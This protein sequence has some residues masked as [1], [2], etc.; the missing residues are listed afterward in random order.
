MIV[1]TISFV[2]SFLF[3]WSSLFPQNIFIRNI[4]R[5]DFNELKSPVGPQNWDVAQDTLG[6]IWVANTSTVL[7]FDG[8]NWSAV[9]STENKGIR[10]FI[11]NDDQILFAGGDE[12]IG[13]FTQD[14][15]GLPI[16]ASL[17]HLLKE[18]DRDIGTVRSVA[19]HNNAVFFKT[20][21]FLIMYQ[22]DSVKIW[23]A[24]SRQNSLS[25]LDDGILFQNDQYDLL[26]LKDEKIDTLYKFE[27]H[28]S[29]RIIKGFN[30]EPNGYILFS[31]KSGIYILSGNQLRKYPTQIDDLLQN[32][33]IEEVKQFGD[34][35][36]VLATKGAGIIFLDRS[37]SLIKQINT[38]KG[39][40]SN[41]CYNMYRDKQ[42]GW[43]LCLDNGISRMEYP[44]A[45]T[46]FDVT[47]GLEGIVLTTLNTGDYLYVGTT[48]GLY[49]IQPDSEENF[50][51]IENVG[52][53]WDVKSMNERIWVASSDGIF[54]VNKT[55]AKKIVEV[56]ARTI[57]ASHHSDLIWAGL[58]K[59]FGWLLLS[60]GTWKWHES[61]V[62]VDHQIRTIAQENDSV[63][64][65]SD[66]KLSRLVFDTKR[67]KMIR[68]QTF[69]KRQGL[70]EDFWIIESYIINNKLLLGTPKGLYRFDEGYDLFIPDTT[71]GKLFANQGRDAYALA[72]DPKGQFWLS[73]NRASG[74]LIQQVDG[75]YQWD[76]LGLSRLIK[77]D[78]W[79]IVP[80]ANGIVWFCTT[81]GL[82]KYD[83][84]VKSSFEKNY[85]TLINQIALNGDSVIFYHWNFSGNP[86]G[87]SIHFPVLDFNYNSIRFS[88]SSTSYNVGE[89]IQY[90]YKLEGYDEHWS[91]WVNESIKEYTELSPKTYHFKIKSRNLY[92]VET[93]E[94][95]FSFSILPPW[96]R[97]WLAY[98]FYG[99]F[100]IGL[101]I[102]VD[103]IQRKR[104]YLRQQAKIR[105]QEK[106]LER[107]REIS[108]KLRKVDKLKDEFL[109][110]TSHEL[111]TP[112]NGIIGIS[113]SL[114]D[115]LDKM[116]RNLV[117]KNLSM[118]VSS[119][120]RLANMVNS[121]LDYSKLKSKELELKI[122]K[123][124]LSSL[125]EIVLTM[126]K[127]LI[128]SDKVQILNQIPID[129]PMVLA[130]ENRLQQILYNLIGNAI[131]FTEK[132]SIS[133][134]AEKNNNMALI[135]VKD[136]GM[137]IPEDKK[138][139][140]FESYEQ[141]DLDVNREFI[142]T[143]LGLT[144]S[145][146]LVEL[147]GGSIWVESSLNTGSRFYFT[148]PVSD[149]KPDPLVSD[150]AQKP[151][152]EEIGMKSKV[153]GKGEFKIL[154]VD[155][156]PVNR[157]VL[158]NHLREEHYHLTLA[159]SGREALELIEREPFDLILLDVMM[160]GT[161]GYEVCLKI[162]EVHTLNEL[163]VIFITAKD[164][165]KDLVEGLSYGGNDYIT[166]PFSKQE[167]L[168]RIRTHLKLLKIN[169]SYSRFIP[170]EFI[171][172]LGRESIM[173]VHLGD[174]I[175][176]E[177]T[178]L[179]TDIRDYT[180][181]AEKMS[182]SENF[183]FLNSFLSKI[184]PVIRKN[185][186]FIMH[187]LGDGLMALFPDDASNAVLASVEIQQALAQFNMAG[188]EKIPGTVQVGTGMHTG[189]LILGILGDD[190]RMDANV[191]SDAVNTASRM[192]GLTKYYGASS[193]ISE[194]T[195]SNIRNEKEINH[196]FLGLVRVKGKS[197]PLKIYELLDGVE[198]E[199]NRLKIELKDLF[200]KG[201]EH[202]FSQ[203]FVEAASVFK[204]V[205]LKNP[206]DLG[207]NKYL[208]ICARL[209]VDG[210]DDT[211]DGVESMVTK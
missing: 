207:A 48:N 191:V 92:K 203:E 15:R 36:Y 43:W 40:Q 145:K 53:V 123:V 85:R 178:I 162:R 135:S 118:V 23:E 24:K 131:K 109:A 173:D 205:S 136:T 63:L 21:D 196:R 20:S 9:R 84:R 55:I 122:K 150:L 28:K 52:E 180:T 116:D 144:I 11:L 164:Q 26:V 76:T 51:R 168:A 119:G 56:K 132:G 126:S 65:V 167:L 112:L 154:I 121:I 69:D 148:L 156:E 38:R 129:F 82:Y 159:S 161:S 12:D 181:L 165:I 62:Q 97:T 120:K 117:L 91:D 7:L 138:E 70:T 128:S 60:E 3:I 155:D 206:S 209:M 110:H 87:K 195:L 102:V 210:V 78:I 49:Y 83:T 183:K 158:I 13:Y 17:M 182:P 192:E 105:M 16:Y 54:I 57:A 25:Q 95:S 187:Y 208:R 73:S 2:F 72:E 80:D 35:Q 115:Q 89:N 66:D 179:F 19:V 140:I 8:I 197:N 176:K 186:G 184:G 149:I 125:V 32:I 170:Y 189:K 37:G 81:D 163:P 127:P 1:K 6:R 146:N 143:G 5:N 93:K 14:G 200:E 114:Q 137:G 188:P 202:Y 99:L 77:T 133:I 124:D 61:E 33:E 46:Y 88:F 160:P 142:G 104:L 106:E 94:T 147:H 96:Y 90:S 79:R 47:N 101:I 29:F 194:D 45:L 71:Y 98:G 130:D 30:I 174:Q 193:I 50:K 175:E 107:E 18:E 68:L 103:R 27:N 10:N 199:T 41:T 204:T 74:P 111:R 171:R 67:N 139:R 31:E 185:N 172:S 39:L 198:S 211:W 64:W 100:G 201:L 134:T 151:T 166:K 86:L 44:S 42:E 190:Q 58:E 4:T 157:Q 153:N 34:N 59:G 169:D 108:N 75:T 22:H 113:E 141:L 152:I 177:V